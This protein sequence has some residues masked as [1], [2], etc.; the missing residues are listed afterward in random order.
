M[1]LYV[2]PKV[3]P[4][5][6]RTDA[7]SLDLNQWKNIYMFPP[8]NLMVKV[9]NKLRTFKGTAAIVAPLWP[10]SNWYPLVLELK[11]RLVPLPSPTL[12]QTVQKKS[13]FASSWITNKLHVMIFSC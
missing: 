4:L 10:Q 1:P 7:L 13:V 3:D 12:R 5:I 2:V 9:L 6:M 11:L 8:F